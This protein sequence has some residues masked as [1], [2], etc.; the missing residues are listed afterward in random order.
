MIFDK[1]INADNHISLPAPVYK[2]ISKDC[3]FIAYRHNG[4]YALEKMFVSSLA[5]NNCRF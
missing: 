3:S 2:N 5:L 4:E 1:F